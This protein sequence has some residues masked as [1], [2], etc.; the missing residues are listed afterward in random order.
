M[1]G[2]HV[3][4]IGLFLDVGGVRIPTTVIIHIEVLHLIPSTDGEVLLHI[5]ESDSL[6][7]LS[8]RCLGITVGDQLDP[9]H[10]TLISLLFMRD[11]HIRNPPFTNVVTAL[12]EYGTRIGK[13]G[14]LCI[15]LAAFKCQLLPLCCNRDITRFI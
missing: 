14:C 15:V 12:D 10:G 1:D 4:T 11:L 3:I 5:V 6:L 8:P 9:L 13:I 2:K 7:I